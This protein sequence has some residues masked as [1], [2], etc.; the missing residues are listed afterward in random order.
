M[1]QQ[2]KMTVDKS[3]LAHM[4]SPAKH[5]LDRLPQAAAATVAERR[6][7]FWGQH[8]NGT[9]LILDS[10]EFILDVDTSSR[11][12]RISRRVPEVLWSA[13]Y[14]YTAVWRLLMQTDQLGSGETTKLEEGT[15]ERVAT[16]L[17]AWAL[18]QWLNAGSVPDQDWLE[19]TPQPRPRPETPEDEVDI[20]GKALTSLAFLLQ[21]EFAHIRLGHIGLSNFDDE[22]EADAEA[23]AWFMDKCPTDGKR[24]ARGHA[25]ATALSIIVARDIH[26]GRLPTRETHP[27]SYDRL[28]H[29]LERHFDQDETYLWSYVSTILSLHITNSSMAAA[30]PPDPSEPVSAYDAV[31][32]DLNYL[33]DSL[34]ST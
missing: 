17:F 27:R 22:K 1:N 24:D 19:G 7:E 28:S 2:S 6:D 4:T 34:A 5:I 26:R 16:R 33:A 3:S 12:I 11:Q 20:T 21:H 18:N 30:S 9:L 25:I 29:S 13:T 23:V 31:Q 8:A 15:K 10:P 32:Q 14:A